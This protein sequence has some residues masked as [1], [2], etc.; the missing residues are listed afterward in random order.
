MAKI[1][2]R[3]LNVMENFLV[4]KMEIDDI[5]NVGKVETASYENPWPQDIFFRALAENDHAHYFVAILHD[6]VIGYGGMWLVVDD[7]QITNIA[8]HPSYRGHKFGEKLFQYIFDYGAH[9]GMRRLSLEV[10]KSN[11]VAQRMYQKF[12]LVRAGIRKNYYTDDG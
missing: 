7:A 5:S 9:H 2:G 12:G 8:I 4:R 3:G 10:R 11:I 6:E 1:S